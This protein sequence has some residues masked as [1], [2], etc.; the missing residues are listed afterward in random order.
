LE[1]W[2]PFF[3]GDPADERS[4]CSFQVRYEGDKGAIIPAIRAAV[5]QAAPDVPPVDIRPMNDL[6]G[7]TLIAE[8]LISQLATFFGL[9]AL[10]LASIGLYGVMAFNVAARTNEIGIRAALGAQP[11]DILR[12]VM[13]ETL[14]LIA[15][16]VALGL[17]S[18]LAAKLWLSSQLFG[19][20]ALDPAAIGAATGVLGIATLLA[21][22]ILARWASRVDPV[23]ALHYE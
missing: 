4:F 11:R 14:F 5:K 1:F 23:V 2:L 9:L 3:H 15:T 13:R 17:P 8:K 18:I 16:G 7:E 10:T 19:L 20:T 12:G 6:M 22:Y 21:G